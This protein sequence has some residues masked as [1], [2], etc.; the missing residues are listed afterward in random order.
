[1]GL[2]NRNLKGKPRA[3]SRTQIIKSEIN[4][5]GVWSWEETDR[6]SHSDN[7]GWGGVGAMKIPFIYTD[8][9]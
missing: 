4:R 3:Q 2:I 1:M 9:Q 8:R 7:A 5:G 6:L